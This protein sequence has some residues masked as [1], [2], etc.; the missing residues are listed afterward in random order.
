MDEVI[1][2][3]STFDNLFMRDFISLH[4]TDFSIFHTTHL[5]LYLYSENHSYAL[6][7]DF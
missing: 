1:K 2:L 3:I 4:K 6:I 5:F 7:S